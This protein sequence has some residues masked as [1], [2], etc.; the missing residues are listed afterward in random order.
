MIRIIDTN[1]L[2]LADYGASHPDPDCALEC[3]RYLRDTIGRTPVGLDAEGRILAE[4][5]V[6][7]VKGI[8]PGVGYQLLLYLYT[9]QHDPRWGRRVDLHDHPVR[10][11]DEFPE[12][13]D[14]QSF[15]RSDR[16]FVAVA[17]ACGEDHEIANAADS[18]WEIWLPALES[19]GVNVRFLCGDSTS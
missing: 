7:T 5:K 2:V 17:L 15:D 4:Y 14:L 16:K 1:V 18:D 3:V 10:E 13:P 6:N 19:N 8:Q 9:N 11:F 12:S